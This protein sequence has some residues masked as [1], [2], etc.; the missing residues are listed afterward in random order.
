MLRPFLQARSSQ[1]PWQGMT[2]PLLDMAPSAPPLQPWEVGPQNM[3]TE[4]EGTYSA[5]HFGRPQFARTSNNKATSDAFFKEREQVLREWGRKRE[6][7]MHRKPTILMDQMVSGS[8]LYP[9]R[10]LDD[11]WFTAEEHAKMNQLEAMLIGTGH[12]HSLSRDIL[13]P[14]IYGSEVAIVLDDSGSMNL[15]MFGQYI[16]H[17]GDISA[18]SDFNSY[19]L[20]STLRR[21]LPGGW[22]SQARNFRPAECPLSPHHSRWFFARHHLHSWRQIFS[23]L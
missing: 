12:A 4:D 21:S 13:T 15:D 7:R 1:E 16:R 2:Q 23:I 20:D 6:A 11:A 3:Y 5:L 17:V 8:E 14:L 9:P 19:L 10:L 22:F 18:T